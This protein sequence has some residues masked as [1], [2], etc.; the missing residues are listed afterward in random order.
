MV[1]KWLSLARV[2]L[3]IPVQAVSQ[4]TQFEC[5]AAGSPGAQLQAVRLSGFAPAYA[6]T[7]VNTADLTDSTRHVAAGMI[8][9]L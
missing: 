1:S 3:D 8:P 4:V 6:L 2:S 9:S 5:G 7:A